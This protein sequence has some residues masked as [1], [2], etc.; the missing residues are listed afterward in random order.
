MTFYVGDSLKALLSI[1]LKTRDDHLSDQV[2]R[3]LVVK[4]LVVVSMGLSLIWFHSETRC[5][6]PVKSKGKE[7]PAQFIHRGCWAKGF[8]IYPQL[9]E[10][11]RKSAYYGIP[12]ELKWNGYR[13][14]DPS[15]LC[16]V[17]EYGGSTDEENCFA[18]E[19]E[20]FN[21]YQWMPMSMLLLSFV[22][23]FP[24]IVFRMVN[25]DLINLRSNLKNLQME[26]NQLA[27]LYFSQ[28][29]NSIRRNRLRVIANY[30]VKCLYIFSNILAM[31]FLHRL[32]NDR[33]YTYGLDWLSWSKGN[34]TER[35]YFEKRETPTP[36]NQLLPI[37]GMCDLHD[38]RLDLTTSYT[39]KMTV[40]CE[41]ASHAVYQHTLVI[42]WF[43]LVFSN[44]MSIVGLIYYLC[45]HLRMLQRSKTAKTDC[46]L[47]RRYIT[48]REMEYLEC[49]KNID[50]AV[51]AKVNKILDDNLLNNSDETPK[52]QGGQPIQVLTM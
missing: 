27:Y 19:R 40:V 48:L 44:A 13:P 28:E 35:L 41:M 45:N 50:L 1:K 18:M 42:I 2:S 9:G 39:D 24:Y 4:V 52:I 21:Q 33:F 43:L 49:I 47:F 3:I 46:L 15:Q 10:H 51:Y 25:T 5:I 20:Y 14:D 17:N 30:G 11:M 6:P 37:F 36:G 23:Y 38:V 32:L 16:R 8:Y 7:L 34:S 26:T 31:S 12:F 22:F 29:I